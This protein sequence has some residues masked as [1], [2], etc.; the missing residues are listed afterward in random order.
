MKPIIWCRML[1]QSQSDALLPFLLQAS[2][3]Q[4][5]STSRINGR[6]VERL[7]VTFHVL[8][9]DALFLFRC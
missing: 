1:S 4:D 7:F 2:S 6:L 8:Q 9:S 5:M 3:A